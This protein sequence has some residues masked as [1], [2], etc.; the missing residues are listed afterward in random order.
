ML[1]PDVVTGVHWTPH[2]WLSMTSPDTDDDMTYPD[3]YQRLRPPTPVEMASPYDHLLADTTTLSSRTR[4]NNSRLLQ[5]QVSTFRG[6]KDNF[7]EFEHLLRNHLQPINHRLPEEAKLQY[8]RN[9]L[10]EEA[11][12]IYQ[13]LTTTT[14]TNFNHV[15]TKFRKDFSKDDLKEKARYKRY[16]SQ[17]SY[18]A[19]KSSPNKQSKRRRTRKSKLSSSESCQYQSSRSSWTATRK[20]LAPTKSRPSCRRQQ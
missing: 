5:T 3:Y 8:F 18:H 1:Q 15:L 13:S 10:R 16:G 19:Y 11:S 9:L 12:G 14:E 6:S 17:T 2:R 4:T 20:M 7:N